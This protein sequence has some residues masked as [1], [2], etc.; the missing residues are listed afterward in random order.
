MNIY[1]IVVSTILVIILLVFAYILHNARSPSSYAS[2][3][4]NKAEKESVTKE[5][6]EDNTLGEEVILDDK[7]ADNNLINR[8]EQTETYLW[9]LDIH[10]NNKYT[11]QLKNNVDN[12][13]PEKYD[14]MNAY[15]PLSDLAE[16]WGVSIEELISYLISENLIEGEHNALILTEKG[17]KLG[18]EY[19]N[20][21]DHEWIEFPK[22]LL[23]RSA[24]KIKATEE[25]ANEKQ[26]KY[27]N[28]SGFWFLVIVI[29]LGYFFMFR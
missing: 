27:D 21:E 20:H 26:Y 18:G 15:L 23:D 24:S 12:L 25:T 16:L 17:I 6:I 9:L 13:D 7:S 11:K 14:R 2:D 3:Y 10:K 19:I 8:K 29:I 4:F 5:D 28:S 22:D 1:L